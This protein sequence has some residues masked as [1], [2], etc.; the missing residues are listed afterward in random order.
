MLIIDFITKDDRST[1]RDFEEFLDPIRNSVESNTCGLPESLGNSG[2][3]ESPGAHHPGN[4]WGV[5]GDD[6]TPRGIVPNFVMPLS[7]GIQVCDPPDTIT[8]DE[9][10]SAS[11]GLQV[12][13]YTFRII[14]YYTNRA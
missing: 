1:D 14:E 7:S 12:I 10:G 3:R 9:R 4:P 8:I 13:P 5:D 6:G 2:S 11:D